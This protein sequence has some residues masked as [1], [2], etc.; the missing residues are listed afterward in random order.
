[1]L[2]VLTYGMFDML[3]VDTFIALF[4]TYA[5]DLI[6]RFLRREI[7]KKNISAKTLMDDRLLL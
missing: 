7:A 4:A 5:V 6:V 1:M 3:F 2:Q